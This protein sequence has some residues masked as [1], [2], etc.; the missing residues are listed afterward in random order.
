MIKQLIPFLSL[1]LYL[2]AQTNHSLSFNGNDDYVDFG[3][4]SIYNLGLD[5][6]SLTVFIKPSTDNQNARVICKG[7]TSNEGSVQL[8][9]DLNG[10]LRLSF[11]NLDFY[12]L[13]NVIQSNQWQQI[14]MTRSG[15]L[16][17]GFVN[18]IEV[19]NE[20]TPVLDLTNN[21]PFVFGFEPGFGSYFN[22]LIDDVNIWSM[23]LTVSQMQSYMSNSLNGD[24]DGLL[25]SWNFNEGES[26]NLYDLTGDLIGNI[27]GA[28]WSTDVPVTGCTDP[29]AENYNENASIDDGSCEYPDNG[30][31]SVSFDGVDDY[32][33]INGP[34]ASFS[35]QVTFSGW[36]LV[37]DSTKSRNPLFGKLSEDFMSFG[38]AL[39]LGHLNDNDHYSTVGFG[40]HLEDGTRP[41]VFGGTIKEN[42][43]YFIAATYDGDTLSLYLD[44]V[45][46]GQTAASGNIANVTGSTTMGSYNQAND[47]FLFGSISTLSIWNTALTQEQVQSNMYS[48]LSG[49]ETGLASY[50]N[51]NEGSGDILHDVSYNN[52]NNGIINGATWSD[53]VPSIVE[54]DR[55][56]DI[57]ISAFQGNLTDEDN[58]L[59]VSVDAT[60]EFDNNFDEIEPP[61]SPGSE[62]KV[63]FPHPEWQHPLGNNFSVDIR[64]EMV[65][66][67][68]K[69]WEMEIVSTENGDVHLD[70][71]FDQV[72]DLPVIMENIDTGEE[73]LL[74]DNSNYTFTAEADEVYSFTITVG[75]ITPPEVELVSSPNGPGVYLANE[76]QTIT[77]TVDGEESLNP[78]FVYE[79]F[80]SGET[81]TLIAQSEGQNSYDYV[82]PGLEVGVQYGLM[83]KVEVEDDAG[84]VGFTTNKRPF[85]VVGS[86]LSTYV[87]TGWNL[88]SSPVDPSDALLEDNLDDDFDDSYYIGYNWDNNGYNYAHYL[89]YNQGYWLG[90]T[91]DAEVDVVGT[92]SQIDVTKELMMGWELIGNPLLLNVSVDSLMFDNGGDPIFYSD[93]LAQGWINSVYG[94]GEFGYEEVTTL[95]PWSAYWLGVLD[96]DINVTFPYHNQEVHRDGVERDN[97]WYINFNA[98]IQGATDNLLTIGSHEDASDLFDIAF[99]KF[100]P[101]IPPTPDQVSLTIAHPEWNNTFEDEYKKDIRSLLTEGSMKQWNIET[102]S[103]SETVIVTWDFQMVPNE[104]EVTYSIN[105]GQSFS[106]LRNTEEIIL[107]H[108]TELIVRVGTQVLS[109]DAPSLPT[110]F[111]LSQNYPNPFNPTT[112]IMYALPEA[113]LVTVA[114]YDVTGRKIAS[115]INANQSAGYHSLQWD[116][117]ND[118]GEGISAGMYIYTIQAGEYRSTKKMVLLK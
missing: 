4:S 85:T 68:V 67:S 103:S 91:Q 80:D 79:S 95:K 77:W 13:E 94:Y 40:F 25:A 32:I 82:L 96:D 20:I 17:K 52:N 53:D 61:S 113:S 88:W 5:D 64:S 114:V 97:G 81:F 100:S 106:N 6:F 36:L 15:D 71:Y 90:T 111:S 43:W 26:S 28:T 118:I 54:V 104:Y 110:S 109:I 117:T 66:P 45:L 86:Y 58:Y 75:D 84:N 57:Q 34:I 99:D 108:D 18:G 27:Y 35:D 73:Q 21:E 98:S 30:D 10:K 12:S 112:Q 9:I 48:E 49:D 3:T 39:Y 14:G 78:S 115:L 76:T 72:P 55:D 105:D 11:N 116:A 50:W 63:Y 59:G 2:N 41:E 102:H 51:F 74:L 38:D 87:T 93:A 47:H 107:A 46:V 31:Y 62:L 19:I 23:A 69:V 22:G 65:S 89:Y 70:V 101:P 42:Y 44:G 29:H 37:K 16:I 92:I 56:W 60:D 24:E 8:N 33:E 7:I 83:I 1:V